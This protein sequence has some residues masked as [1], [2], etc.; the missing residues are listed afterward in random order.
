MNSVVEAIDFGWIKACH[1]ISEGGLAVAAAEMAFSSGLGVDLWLR[2][3]SRSR[4]L[5]RDD[6]ILFSESN[7][8]F[9]V[10]VDKRHGNDFENLIQDN[11][12]SIIGEVKKDPTFSVHSR[13]DKPL[14]EA[15]VHELRKA[16]KNTLG[17]DKYEA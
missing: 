1:D 14:V 10:E 5:T 3:A 2:N 11:P 17:A 16:W 13:D 12:C 6:F 9:L 15:T 8:R 7:S 4:N